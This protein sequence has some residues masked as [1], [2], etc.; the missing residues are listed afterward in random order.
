MRVNCRR[1]ISLVELL[2]V[3][4]VSVIIVA[5][6]G[7]GMQVMLRAYRTA[8]EHLVDGQIVQRLAA[9]LRRDV[10]SAL[11]AEVAER[12][13][14]ER[15][16]LTDGFGMR[17]EY[18][19]Q[20]NIVTR[21]ELIDGAPRQCDQFKLPMGSR[22]RF[23][24]VGDHSARMVRCVIDKQP[25]SPKDGPRREQSWIARLGR[26]RRFVSEAR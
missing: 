12:R 17:V 25:K 18:S 21:Q 13:D 7:G 1:G 8:Q 14:F 10:R 20:T 9:T 4:T 26:D 23:E 6:I 2:V 24:I 5:L 3:M 15:L 22:I 11:N 19:A 16:V